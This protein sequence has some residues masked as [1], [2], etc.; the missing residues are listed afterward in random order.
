MN[1]ITKL[2]KLNSR[3][4]RKTQVFLDETLK[5]YQLTSACYPYL[6]TLEHNEGISQAKISCEIGQ[7]KGMS[8]RMISKLIKLDYVIKEENKEDSRACKLYLTKKAKDLVPFIRKDIHDLIQLITI[9]LTE[10]EKNITINSLNKVLNN[11]NT[12]RGKK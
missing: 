8:A 4:F 10:E 2:L 3:I 12:N 5:K 11:I 9:D 1:D 7:D 6:L